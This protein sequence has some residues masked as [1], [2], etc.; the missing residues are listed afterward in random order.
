MSITMCQLTFSSYLEPTRTGKNPLEEK[1]PE[2]QYNISVR[3]PIRLSM[4]LCRVCICIIFQ[5]GGPASQC[6]LPTLGSEGPQ[7][8]PVELICLYVSLSYVW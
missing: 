7:Y 3:P 8:G 1:Y 6:I 2:C 4:G 5:C